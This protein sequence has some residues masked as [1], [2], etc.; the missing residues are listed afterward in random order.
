MVQ[1]WT[2]SAIDT[3]GFYAKHVLW[4]KRNIAAGFRDLNQKFVDVM[5]V[6]D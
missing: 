6:R 2:R 5:L 1:D 4:N 3:A